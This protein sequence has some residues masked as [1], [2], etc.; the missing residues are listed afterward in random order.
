MIFQIIIGKNK[1]PLFLNL[2][3][4]TLSNVLWKSRLVM[5]TA[6]EARLLGYD[7]CLVNSQEVLLLWLRHLQA[8]PSI[9]ILELCLEVRSFLLIYIVCN[10]FFDP[11]LENNN[12]I[13][14]L[15][16]LYE[17]K[18]PCLRE[19]K[20]IM[21]LPLKKWDLILASVHRD[22]LCEQILEL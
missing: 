11:S 21:P 16:F 14:H 20:I 2:M 12:D 15:L 8:R 18:K 4:E 22:E 17:W 6:K 1:F 13:F 7:L 10:N 9:I 3:R 5:S 19:S